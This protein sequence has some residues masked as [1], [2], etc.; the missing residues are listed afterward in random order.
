MVKISTLLES[1]EFASLP[2]IAIKIIAMLNDK[3]VD[4]RDVAKVVAK[5]VILTHQILRIANSALYSTDNEIKS[6]H[7]A[8]VTL[9]LNRIMYFVLA[10]SIYS[11][12]HK[13]SRYRKMIKDYWWHGLCTGMVAKALST[14]IFKVYKE[15]EF[16]GGLIHDIGKLAMMIHNP[17]MFKKTIS[18][19]SRNN[20]T[21]LE[22]EESV[23]GL[24]HIRL[25][26]EIARVW[27]LPSEIQMVISHHH[28]PSKIHRHSEIVSIVRLADILCEIWGAGFDEGLKQVN[29][30]EEIAW[31]VL[32]ESFP[33]LSLLD[34]ELFTFEIEDSFRKAAEFQKILE[35]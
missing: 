20:V 35:D 16:L 1:N 5:D 34:I 13:T 28:D 30:K 29:L 14:K 18:L 10:I 6:I 27:K 31:K 25:G 32:K 3:N 11:K 33:E 8:I 21:D 22:A 23:Y 15:G 12:F 24:N 4:M 2:Q 7:Q 26:D 17:E 19:A 9:G